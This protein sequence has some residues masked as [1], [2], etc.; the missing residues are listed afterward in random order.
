MDGVFARDRIEMIPHWLE[1][2]DIYILNVAGSR[3]S[4]HPGIYELTKGIYIK[5]IYMER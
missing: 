1:A 2:H 4:K 3:E 5:H